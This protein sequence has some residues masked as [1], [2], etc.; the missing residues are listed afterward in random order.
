MSKNLNIENGEG[1]PEISNLWH[2]PKLSMTDA[3]PFHIM[4]PPRPP[5]NPS[6]AQT[7]IQLLVMKIIDVRKRQMYR[8]TDGLTV[9][10]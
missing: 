8:L 7:F 2:S 10:H 5:L 6:V 9:Q 4:N 1:I 3:A